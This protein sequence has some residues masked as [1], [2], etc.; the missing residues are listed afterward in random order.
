VPPIDAAGHA[1]LRK[2]LLGVVQFLQECTPG[3][4]AL[5]DFDRLRRKLGLLT[6]GTPAQPAVGSTALDVEALSTAELAALQPDTLTDEQVEQAFQAAQKLDA[7]ELANRFATT[8]IARPP[9]TDRPDRFP[10][11][12]FLVQTALA[13]G[14]T[15]TALQYVDEGE[16]ADCEQNEGRR[17]NDYELRRAQVLA[18]SGDSE[19]AQD[20]FERLIARAPNELRYCGTAA[21]LILSV[22]RG[23]AARHFAE[24]GLA[25][26]RQ[27]NNRE[28]EQYFLELVGAAEKQ[29]N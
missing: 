2:Q 13:E 23:A 6:G 1:K 11:Y 26:A 22:K 10:W 8:L 20:V 28:S 14:D 3:Q 18:K 29:G 5:Y 24:Q 17:R 12:T 27:Q 7:R 9:R 4:P 21:E 16:K 15:Q 19:S 25:K